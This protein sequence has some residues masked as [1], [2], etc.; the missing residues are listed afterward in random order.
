MESEGTIAIIEDDVAIR[1]LVAEVLRANGFVVEGYGDAAAFFRQADVP[2]LDC[3]ILDLMLPGES[4]L[5]IC[6]TLRV[7]VPQLP[8]LMVTAKGDDID[9]IIGLECGADDYLPKPF[10]SRELLARLR[11]ILRRTK[12]PGQAVESPGAELYR[13]AGWTLA[14]DS[15]DLI[16]PDGRPVTLS[17]GEFDLLHALVMHPRRVLS[18]DLL[19]DMTRGRMATPYDRAIDVQLSRLR[20]KLGDDP[21]EPVMIRTVRGDGYLFAPSVLKI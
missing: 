6:Q 18:R 16:D 19:L 7:K 9:R 14:V 2:S 11:A 4:G 8:I 15:R 20:R 1:D 21:R 5:S 13:F 10:N 12:A 17:T 3:L